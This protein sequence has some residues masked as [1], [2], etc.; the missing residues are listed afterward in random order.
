[1]TQRNDSKSPISINRLIVV[2]VHERERI[3][4]H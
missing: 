1:M 3:A 4:N 2:I